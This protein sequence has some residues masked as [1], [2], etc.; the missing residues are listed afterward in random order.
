MRTIALLAVLAAGFVAAPSIALSGETHPDNSG[1]NERDRGAEA[2]TP[3]DQSNSE[4]DLRITQ[5]IRK[6]VV[7]NDD[8]SMNAKNVKI[9]TVAGVVTLRGPVA[10]AE[11]RTVI[12][13]LARGVAGVVNVNNQ[14]EIASN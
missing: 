2:V 13:T 1:V 6:A 12:A 14:L 9:V 3:G 8:L 5:Q 10:S 7:A 11:E 4:E